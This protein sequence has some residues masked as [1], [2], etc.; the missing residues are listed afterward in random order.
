MGIIAGALSGLGEGGM[1]GAKLYGEYAARTSLQEQ[2]AEI[3]K[4]RDATLAAARRGELQL[5]SEL[6]TQEEVAKENR[7]TGRY[8]KA[9]ETAK[10]MIGARTAPSSATDELGTPIQPFQI[11]DSERSGLRQQAYREAGLPDVALKMEQFDVTREDE[12]AK[13]DLEKQ[14]L[15][16]ESSFHKDSLSIQRAQANS[17][18]DH[19]AFLPQADGTFMKQTAD[20]RVLGIATDPKTGKPLQGPKDIPASIKILM[21]GNTKQMS[22]LESSYRTAMDD[23]EKRDIRA[24]I[25]GL[26]RLN[27]QLAGLKADDASTITPT[28]EDI[29]GLKQRSNNPAAVSFFENKYGKGSAQQYLATPKPFKRFD[30]GSGAIP[31]LQQADAQSNSAELARFA[32][33]QARANKNRDMSH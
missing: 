22:V 10:G 4:M 9:E 29:A 19:V 8:S 25:D 33:A 2:E 31:A 11:S 27:T 12:R 1:A 3:Q 20:G 32:A 17:W 5:A 28:P 18:R 7:I 14:R 26:Q 24:Q 6:R 15:E 16:N 30:T 13:R 23:A 21:E